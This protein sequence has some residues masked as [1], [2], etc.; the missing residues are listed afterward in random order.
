MTKV[1]IWCV[2]ALLALTVVTEAQTKK[3]NSLLGGGPGTFSTV[4]GGDNTASILTLEATSNETPIGA[5]I[6]IPLAFTTKLL[7]GPASQQLIL[8]PYS[9]DLG[10]A[11]NSGGAPF[12]LQPTFHYNSESD[13][14][15]VGMFVRPLFD[16]TNSTAIYFTAYNLKIGNATT[17]VP[18]GTKGQLSGYESNIDTAQE[19]ADLATDESSH[20]FGATLMNHGGASISVMDAVLTLDTVPTDM[21]S[22]ARGINIALKNNVVGSIAYGTFMQSTGTHKVTAAYAASGD[23]DWLMDFKD[24][25][26]ITGG[27][28]VRNNTAFVSRNFSDDTDIPIVFLN[29]NNQVEVGSNIVNN[30]TN[31]FLRLGSYTLQRVDSG[32]AFRLFK[33]DFGNV[34]TLIGSNPS[35]GQTA[36][37][38]LMTKDGVTLVLQVEVCGSDTAG[39]GKRALCIAN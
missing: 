37:S 1:L 8:N 22:G 18:S 30:V 28:R 32:D 7:I 23:F 10:G 24:A 13:Y 15:A 16:V 34:M 36:M 14:H 4:Y 33:E 17:P 39:A 19:Q 3:R 9:D 31:P 20:A 26:A 11:G 2:V 27:I 35:N 5:E 12:V 25:S 38:L 6:I 29:T 21:Q